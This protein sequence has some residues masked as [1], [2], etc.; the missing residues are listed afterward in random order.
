MSIHE[1][2]SNLLTKQERLEGPEL[3]EWL[4]HVEAP[5]CLADFVLQ[6]QLPGRQLLEATQQRAVQ[7]AQAR[8]QQAAGA[9]GPLPPALPA[10]GDDAVPAPA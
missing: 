7:R 1:G 10:L 4:A 6:G 5:D 9:S 8:R 2:L 3:A